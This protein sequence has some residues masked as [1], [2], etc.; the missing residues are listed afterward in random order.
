[1]YLFSDWGLPRNSEQVPS[2]LITSC[3]ATLLMR[4]TCRERQYPLADVAQIIDSAVTSLHPWSY[5]I[6][7][8]RERQYPLTSYSGAKYPILAI[9]AS[10]TCD[11][12]RGI[13][14]Q[15]PKLVSLGTLL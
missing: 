9:A 1:M 14:M 10:S 15:S 12:P 5:D 8:C 3:L 6:Q 4:Q 2:E 11:C 13:D 7:T